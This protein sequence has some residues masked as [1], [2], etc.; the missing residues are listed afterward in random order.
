MR[1]HLID[2]YLR[3]YSVGEKWPLTANDV[4]DISRVVVI[5]AYAEK[6]TLLHTL[7]SL[8]QNPPAFLQSSLTVCV[9]NNTDGSP[10]A[11]RENNR[12]TVEY[13]DALVKGKSLKNF[14]GDNAPYALLEKIS[15]ARLRLGYIDAASGGNAMPQDTGGVGLARKI[16]MDTALRLLGKNSVAGN[17]IL[18]LDADTLV[19]SN[20]L[21]TVGNHF[22]SGNMTAVLAYEHQ[23]PHED[24]HQAAMCCYEVFL[25]YW[26]LGLKYAKSPWAFHCIGSAFAV[27]PEAYAEVRGMN[28]RKA[29]EDFYFLNKAAKTGRI[30]YIK[31][32]CVYPS[33]RPSFRVPFGTGKRIQRFLDGKR[34]EEEYRLYDPTIFV[35]LAEWLQLMNER[36]IRDGEEILMKSERIHPR[37]RT[38]LQDN[39]FTSVWSRICGNARDEKTL[40]RQF[41]GWFDGFKTL[42]MINCF[43]RDVYPQVNMFRALETILR[44][45]GISGLTFGTETAILPLPEQT[46]ILRYLRTIT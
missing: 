4:H 11:A 35:V 8:A 41:H 17:V 23:L 31:D 13:L 21:S 45:S 22:S 43:T 1:K 42:K 28:R 32:T 38:F 9:V 39:G 10:P 5:P 30:D 33:A 44:L 18:S 15:D 20:Y 40:A 19:Q 26:I 2:D 34:Y 25:R 29:G 37:L 7:A 16:G 12:K 36:L 3:K 6:E 14:D 24:E 27:S 46:R